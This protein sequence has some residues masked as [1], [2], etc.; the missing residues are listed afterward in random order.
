MGR[1]HDALE[2][3]EQERGRQG[4]APAGVATPEDLTEQAASESRRVKKQRRRERVAAG[5]RTRVMISD[6]AS[7]V[8]E[9][10]RT[11]RAR[12]QSIRLQNEMRSIVVTSALPGEGKS[13]TAMNLAMCFGLSRETRTCLVDADLRTPFLH[14][15]L[16]TQPEVGL[17][18]VLE[19]DAKLEEAL[20]QV[21]ETSLWVLP[22]RALPTRPSE[23]LGSDGMRE[24]MAELSSRFDT[25]VVD[26]PPVLGLPDTTQLVDLCD[27]ALLVVSAGTTN[28]RDVEAS[29]ERI[30]ASKILGTVMNRCSGLAQP[31]GYR[32]S[33]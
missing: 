7:G 24:L 20:V 14:K 22:V 29:V 10:Y 4:A 30:D 12:I 18:E 13:T 2:R 11:L 6:M 25:I 21:P 27:A 8:S 9:E 28:R 33:S 31:H 1:I 23:L 16:P 3:A 19:A 17:A 15:V 32:R 5:R 26:S